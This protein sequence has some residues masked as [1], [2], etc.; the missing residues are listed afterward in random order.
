MIAFQTRD[1]SDQSVI[2]DAFCALAW[3]HAGADTYGFDAKQIVPVGGSMWGGD[4][5]ILGL[6]AVFPGTPGVE[7]YA[8]GAGDQLSI[9][10]VALSQPRT[11]EN[12]EDRP[13]SRATGIPGYRDTCAVSSA[14]RK[15]AWRG[16]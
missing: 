9:R 8:L 6:V 1:D 13:S 12:A 4:A 10:S 7:R 11:A 15:A 14:A 5:A 3:A 2:Q 16:C